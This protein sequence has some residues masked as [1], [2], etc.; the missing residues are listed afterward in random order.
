M[1][2]LGYR[3]GTLNCCLLSSCKFFSLKMCMVEA[4]K[5][6]GFPFFPRIHLAKVFHC[7]SVLLF[8]Y[9]RLHMF[10]CIMFS[11]Y[12]QPTLLTNL[13][14]HISNSSRTSH[15]TRDMSVNFI[16]ENKKF[17]KQIYKSNKTLPKISEISK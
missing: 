17:S 8:L 15:A 7:N 12:K 11:D 2:F 10:L 13:R 4:K 16:N 6:F 3:H 5:A 9:R 1:I 14:T